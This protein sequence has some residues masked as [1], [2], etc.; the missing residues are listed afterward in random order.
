MAGH[1]KD[2]EILRGL[3]T[4]GEKKPAKKRKSRRIS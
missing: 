2:L 3:V 1:R 4:S